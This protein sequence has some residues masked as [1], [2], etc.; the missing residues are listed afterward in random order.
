MAIKNAT[1]IEEST[2]KWLSMM[3]R[4]CNRFCKI[5]VC[6]SSHT[7][8]FNWILI[9]KKKFNKLLLVLWHFLELLLIINCRE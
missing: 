5:M 2:K 3:A 1:R 9:L 8:E 7:I 4:D 6:S